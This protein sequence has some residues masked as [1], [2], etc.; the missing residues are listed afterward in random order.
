M[1]EQLNHWHWWIL[2]ILLVLL[3]MFAPGVV[4][5]WLGIAAGIVG[6][7]L[8]LFP[9]LG[10]EYQLLLFSSLSV[11]SVVI[12]RV[13]QGKRPVETDQPMLNQRGAQYIGRTFTLEEAMDNNMG[14][15]RVDDT[16]WKICGEDCAA[17]TRV[18]VVGVDGVILKVECQ[19][20]DPQ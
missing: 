2:A 19:P 7:V 20:G 9:D 15:I 6:L 13:V 10:W 5:M 1:Y 14:K 18:K 12:W 3:E 11:V 16:T 17:G 4:F 8:Y